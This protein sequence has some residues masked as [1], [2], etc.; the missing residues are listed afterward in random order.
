M[1]K[2]VLSLLA[3]GTTVATFAQQQ[4]PATSYKKRPTLAVNL[5]MKD[6]VTPDRIRSSSIGKV[7]SDG[8]WAGIKDMS[9]GLGLGYF[10]GITEHIDVNANLAGF[11]TRYYFNDK[12]RAAADNFL[13]E[14]DVSANFKLLTDKYVVNPYLSAGVGGSMYAGSKFGAYI[15]FGAGLQFN[16]G[17]TDAFLF[18]QASYRIPVTKTTTNYN[19]NYSIGFGGPLT[20]KKQPKVVPPPP[21]PVV[22]DTDKD[23]IVDS[24]DKCPAVPGIAKYN[25]C[26]IPDTDKDGIN[27]EN[28]KCPTVP[29]V[30]K[31]NGCPIPD[32]DKDGVNDDEDKC[33]TVAGLARYKGCPIPDTDND[34]VNDEADKCPNEAGPASNNG[35]PIPKITEEKKQKVETAAKKIYFATGSAVLLKK[36][37]PALDAIVALLKET[38]NQTLG[39]DI[40]GHTDNTGKPASNLKLSEARA[41][42][43]LA[44]LTKKGVDAS[45]VS[46]KGFGQTQPVA[47]NKTAA[48]RAQNRRVE[49]KLREM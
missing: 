18:T 42:S 34:G 28:D 2:I 23:G 4:Q 25:G 36:S 37:Y 49:M 27:D 29:G 16:L 20:E 5:L 44:Y 22:V 30:A 19:M 14:G 6:F 33:P 17:G 13:L 12:S 15:P 21:A 8:N 45:R 43:V 26:P 31:Y 39:L 24:L 48:G 10:Q 35:C 46:A 9:A 32:T 3:L 11:F 38:G 40:E 41:K 47:D 1:K 7:L